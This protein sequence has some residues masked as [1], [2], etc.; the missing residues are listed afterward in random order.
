MRVLLVNSGKVDPIARLENDP[1][2]ELTVITEAGYRKHYRPSTHLII[3]DDIADMK[4]VY[5]HAMELHRDRPFDA[6]ASPSERSL[7]TGGYLRSILGLPGPDYE[8]AH[9]FSHKFA[10]KRRL[11]E[12]G[13]PVVAH[14]IAGGVDSVLEAG[15]D[16]PIIVKPALGSGTTTVLRIDDRR[17]FDSLGSHPVLQRLRRSPHP[18]IV[19]RAV[20]IDE[21]FH[22]DGIVVDGKV[23]FAAASKYFEPILQRGEVMMGSYT[24]PVGSEQDRIVLDLHRRTVEALGLRD[25]VTHLEVLREGSDYHVGEISCRPGGAGIP[26]QVLVQFGVDQWDACVKTATGR[27]PTLA[28]VAADGVMVRCQ[29]PL[30]P[31]TVR[32]VSSSEETLDIPG[33]VRAVVNVAPGDTVRGP[34]HSGMFS[35]LVYR[36][37]DAESDVDD[38]VADVDRRFRIEIDPEEP[39]DA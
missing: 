34:W 2:V 24:L 35:A 4:A 37:T 25:G 5:R 36:R 15:V 16:T 29:L 1:E 26:E 28:P 19:E 13:V 10:M 39:A 7:Q 18:L 3:V 30:H 11:A 22:C 23:R 14:G 38:V 17:H 33:V 20:D 27:T 31:G 8:I 6:V 12:R 9:R 32:D 21:E